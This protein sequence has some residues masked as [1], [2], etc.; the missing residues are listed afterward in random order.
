MLAADN[1]SAEE[2]LLNKLGEQENL[3]M[4]DL[5]SEELNAFNSLKSRDPGYVREDKL[6]NETTVTLL[7]PGK[8]ALSSVAEAGLMVEALTERKATTGKFKS[9]NLP[10]M[11]VQA[12]YVLYFR[13]ESTL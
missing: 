5:T 1:K 4:S 7:E 2:K 11:D 3:K 13:E 10:P 6:P 12:P 9:V 8:R